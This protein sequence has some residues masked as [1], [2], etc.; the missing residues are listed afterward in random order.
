M[1][2]LTCQLSGVNIIIVIIY[3][4]S[5][6]FIE[7]FKFTYLNQDIIGFQ[8]KVYTCHKQKT[9]KNLLYF[10]KFFLQVVVQQIPGPRTFITEQEGQ[11]AVFKHGRGADDNDCQGVRVVGKLERRR[12]A[13]IVPA[14]LRVEV[15]CWVF[16]CDVWCLLHEF[17]CMIFSDVSKT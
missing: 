3:T 17:K 12:Y 11:K 7:R 15:D 8:K 13:V 16:G 6:G 9:H 2:S 4:L 1:F 14:D 5:I 10:L